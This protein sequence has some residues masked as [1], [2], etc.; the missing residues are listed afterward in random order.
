[1]NKYFKTFFI[2]LTLVADGV[3][4]TSVKNDTYLDKTHGVIS[5][6]VVDYSNNIDVFISGF[7]DDEEANTQQSN[8]KNTNVDTFFHN[9]KFIEETDETFVSVGLD[10]RINSDTTK[11]F[12]LSVNAR[13]PLSRS[14]KKYN[15]F[16]NDL[17]K[18]NLDNALNMSSDKK[19]SRAEIGINYF[20]KLYKDI[21]SK[22]SIGTNG[23]NPF[24]IAR[25]T[26]NYKYKTW[27]IE[28]TQKF[29]YSLK[30]D[31]EEE[32]KLYFDKHLS[33]TNLFRIIFN[34]STQSN[35]SGMDYG[36]AVQ[37]YQS[38]P[39][40]IGLLLSQSFSGNTE[41]EYNT[42]NQL[43]P[44]QT[45]KD[46]GITSYTTS[47]NFRQNIWRK[48]FFYDVTPSVNFN[49]QNRYEAF[50]SIDFFMQ[51]YFGNLKR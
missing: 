16:I 32:T 35:S 17:T 51:F 4:D 38:Y 3:S 18:D 46:R 15:L 48:W 21:E 49:K 12:N 1:M 22:Y 42:N 10:Y 33:D 40:K 8:I 14:S 36:F 20:T 50:Y 13:L 7:M 6:K 28:P 26:L 37:D 2:L 11:K 47:I 23:I 43:E 41:Y 24:T 25:Y 44:L 34:R 19:E 9:D 39:Y 5:D 45:K 27:D 30:D 29:K 31:F